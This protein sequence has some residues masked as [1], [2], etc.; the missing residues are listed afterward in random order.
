MFS[1]VYP[2][3][4]EIKTAYTTKIYEGMRPVVAIG[5]GLLGA[6]CAWM[7]GRNGRWREWLGGI[8]AVFA[9]GMTA[10]GVQCITRNQ[11]WP[12]DA[13]KLVLVPSLGLGAL[14]GVGAG[15]R[16][17]RRRECAAEAGERRTDG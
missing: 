17:G 10:A 4:V 8:V 5:G 15:A 11:P 1:T 16:I 9:F 2:L 3:L 6:I 12:K 14:L 13:A 7:V